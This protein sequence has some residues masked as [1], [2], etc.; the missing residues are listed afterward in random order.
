MNMI[1][2]IKNAAFFVMLL[3]G[4]MGVSVCIGVGVGHGVVTG[5]RWAL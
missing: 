1:D 5:M 3:A 2:K 4:V